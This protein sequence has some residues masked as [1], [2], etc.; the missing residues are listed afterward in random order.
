MKWKFPAGLLALCCFVLALQAQ[1]Q[2]NVDQLVQ[3]I[4]SELAL[5]QHSDKQV[6][7]YVKKLQLTE[8][9]TDKTILDLEAQGAGPKT[10]QALQELRDQTAAMRPPTHDSTYSPATVPDNPVSAGTPSVSLQSKAAPIPPPNSETQSKILGL[11]KDY[12]LNY[13][14]NLPNFICVQVTRRYI[15]PNAGDH[16]RSIGT[17]LAK[18]GYNEGRE[19]YKVY[20]VNGQYQDTDMEHVGAGGGAISSGE[21]GSLMREIFEPDSNADFGWDHWATLRG[22][23]MAVF[24]YFIDSG[25]SKY[26]IQY[27]AGPGDEQRIITAY[28]GL[29]YADPDTGEI[30]RIKFVA[31]DIPRNFPVSEATEILDYDLVDIS[32]QK[33]VCPMMARLFMT[34][35]RDKSKNEIEFRDYRKFGTESVIQYGAEAPPPMPESQEEPAT[36]STTGTAPAPAA[37]PASNSNS[38][39][40]PGTPEQS[41]KPAASTGGAGNSNP[42]ALPSPPPPPPQ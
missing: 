40:T 31:V 33:Y 12:A 25:H 4:R 14:Q 34:A 16:Y 35:G 26:S 11:M 9:L 5:K 32:G 30:D 15:D 10:V 2:M 20:S 19:N 13:T 37:E 29:I 27:T 38:P 28:K 21:F 18:L 36:F 39:R 22:R 23:R 7:A 41:P 6:A 8:K 1:M 17:V 3:F 42:W 24:N